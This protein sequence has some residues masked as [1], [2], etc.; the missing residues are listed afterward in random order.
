MAA[1]LA[2]LIA[3][4]ASSSADTTCEVAVVGGGWAGI[5]FGYR[6][7]HAGKRVC[8]F[9]RSER[10]GGRTFSVNITTPGRKEMFTMDLGAYRFSPDMHL[11][12]DIVK[13]LGI[14]TECYEPDCE[15][16]NKDMPKPFMFNYSAPLRRVVYKGTKMPGGY[17]TVMMHMV[18]EMESLGALV[19]T[20]ANVVDLEVSE[21]GSVLVFG[22]GKRVGAGIV[23]LNLPRTPL[24][25]LKSFIHAVPLRTKK[26]YECVK[27]DRNKN[28]MPDLKPGK[29]LIKAY[30]YYDDAWWLNALNVS[31]GEFP[32]NAFTPVTT[33]EHV[34]IGAR[35]SDGPIR[36]E[37]YPPAPKGCRGFLEIYYSISEPQKFFVDL[38]KDS[39]TPE[40][41][42]VAGASEDDDAKLKL[43]HEAVLEA[44]T[45][46]FAETAQ[47][48][49]VAKQPP[50]M[51][52]AGI[53]GRGDNPDNV[54]YTAPTKVYYDPESGDTIDKAC[55]VTELTKDEYRDTVLQPL[56]FP[57]VFVANNDWVAEEI[58]Y[59]GG[60]WAEESL[61]QAER[62]LYKL[63]IPKPD[64][65]DG[66]YYL[67]KVVSQTT[68]LP[69][70]YVV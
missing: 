48:K 17:V 46:V 32:K 8:I 35:F 42:L 64:W 14:P 50:A 33:K 56:P 23:L 22:D 36:C 12:G 43:V 1:M 70:T 53:W 30:A 49:S 9:E 11:P 34:P 51:L 15:P 29:A 7:V 31:T 37:A 5:Y 4:A 24:L 40:A 26:M 41:K 16:A 21:S 69:E 67:K 20:A 58:K 62:A 19:Q 2:L 55:N 66:K 61:L 57:K 59:M 6:M 3:F 68:V 13:H 52:L 60:D 44:L 28:F 63:N 45:P 10:I 18:A 38:Q 54:W 25:A 47:P 39:T 65:L 27:F